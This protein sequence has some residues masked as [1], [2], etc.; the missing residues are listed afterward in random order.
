MRC[1]MLLAIFL[2]GSISAAEAE[3]PNIVWVVVE[4]MSAHFGCYGETT[5]KTP[6]VDRLAA[7]GVLFRNAFVT[8]PVCSTCRSALITG[9]YQ[10]SVGAHHHRSSR[11]AEKITLPKHVKLIPWWFKQA[12]YWTCNG[13]EASMMQTSS[14][15][16]RS[17]KTD[18]N[19]DFDPKVYDSSDWSG[20]KKGQPFF[21][22]IQLR[23]GKART[24][25]TPN[26]IK[27]KDVKLPVYY[28]NDPVIRN[29]WAYYM[30]SVMNTDREVGQLVKRL[31]DE[32]ILE[33][34]YIFFITDHG[35]SHARGKQFCYDEGIHIPFIVTG[36]NIK[37]GQVRD[38]LIVQIDMAATSLKLADIEPPDYLDSVDVFAEG[39]RPREYVV[40]ARDR[41]DETVDRIRSV[42][43]HRYKYISN[44][45]PNR[46][47]LQP[48]AYKDGKPIIQ[49]MRRLHNAGKLNAAQ[50][51]IMREKRPAEELFD[52]A[53]DPNELNNLAG[54]QKHQAVL[55]QMRA[56]LAGWTDLTGDQGLKAESASMFDS[57]MAVYLKT[58]RIRKPERAKIIEANIA[59]MKKWAAEGN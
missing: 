14:K 15:K 35:I 22:Q 47:Y 17:G 27:L 3:R 29:D 53:A 7:N 37:A 39:Y 5:I 30:N 28:P 1:F 51:L 32:G 20:R 49:A 38:D 54:S 21:A 13:T 57:D 55:K 9:M 44:L 2:V 24:E 46:P 59:Q 25:K 33:N 41:C 16:K 18:Y 45:L 19:F 52:L 58:I 42:R 36:P 23:G 8:A 43:T 4:D 50:S 26:P 40:S 11:G 34:T 31:K 56:H 10:T 12:G 6:N 48:N